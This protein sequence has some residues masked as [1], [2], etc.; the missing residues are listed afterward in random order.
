LSDFPRLI[1]PTALPCLALETIVVRE[2]ERVSRDA[3]ERQQSEVG[4]K[5]CQVLASLGQYSATD[6]T[7]EMRELMVAAN[8]YSDS[9]STV[10]GGWEGGRYILL[11][12]SLFDAT[13]T[14]IEKKKEVTMGKV[15]SR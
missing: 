5:L 9:N 12:L 3:A 13:T 14:V 7:S 4:T 6:R 2:E 1:P 11:S 8:D 15:R 10:P